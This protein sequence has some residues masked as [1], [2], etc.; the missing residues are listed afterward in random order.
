MKS[1]DTLIK[2]IEAR[3]KYYDGKIT[4][5]EVL[6]LLRAMKQF[7]ENN[8]VMVGCGYIR[9]DGVEYKDTPLDEMYEGGFVAIAKPNYKAKDG[10]IKPA[11]EID[12][13]YYAPQNDC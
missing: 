9:Y 8:Q 13:K 5:R 12:G 3:A 2:H 11:I 10:R 6:K 1:I 7:E 4:I